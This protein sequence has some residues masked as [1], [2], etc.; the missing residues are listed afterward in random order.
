MVS[1]MPGEEETVQV[2]I[3]WVPTKKMYPAVT[4]GLDL[5]ISA[6]YV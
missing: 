6:R 4:F 3:F 1:E 2:P 5:L